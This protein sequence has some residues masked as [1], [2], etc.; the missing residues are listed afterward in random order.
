MIAMMLFK[1]FGG[2]REL[3]LHKRHF[4][5]LVIQTLVALAVGVPSAM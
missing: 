5:A 2:I 3:L 1:V 4:P